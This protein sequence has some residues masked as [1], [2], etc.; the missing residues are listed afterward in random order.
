MEKRSVTV[1]NVT[2]EMKIRD[3]MKFRLGFSS[4][5]IGKVKYGGV[6][7]NG[8]V[9]H[10]RA[11]VKNGDV[12]EVEYPEENSENVLPM[13]IPLTILYEDEDILVVDKPCDMPI[14]PSRGN[15]LPTLANAVRYY[16]GRDFVF[17][18]ITRLDRDTSGVVLI[19]K[20]QLSAAVLGREIMAQGMKKLYRARVTGIPEP[21]M[22]EIFAPIVR[23]SEDSIRR[24]VRED[25][26]D[27]LT[28]YRVISVD[29]EGNALCEVEPVTGRTHQIRVHM[30][31]IGHPLK[32][33]FLYGTQP[34]ERVYELRCVSL[35]FTHPL[36]KKRMTVSVR[37][38]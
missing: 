16:M 26:K 12:I 14:H 37:E 35:S 5:L 23:E 25:G 28:R 31:H 11:A 30:A 19:A 15:H 36:T 20:N 38:V 17:R 18:A 10:M 4:S 3:Y 32:D 21:R 1:E 6:R 13:A 7:L 22:G 8:E 9:V 33:D 34:G 29:E 27:S 2:G 24:V